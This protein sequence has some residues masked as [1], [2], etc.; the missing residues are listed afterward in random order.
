MKGRML[1]TNA[2]DEMRMGARG[3]TVVRPMRAKTTT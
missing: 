3:W 1:E 2:T